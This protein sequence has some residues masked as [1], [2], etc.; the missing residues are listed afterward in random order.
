MIGVRLT[1]KLPEGVTPT[2]L[3][4]TIT[5]LLRKKGVVDKFVEFY[6]PG[7][8]TLT[9]ADRAMIANMAPENGATMLYFPVDEQTLDYLRL[10]GRPT[11]S[12]SK[13]TSR[14]SAS[15]ATAAAPTPNTPT[16]S[17][18]TWARSSPAWP[19]PSARRTASPL[20]QVQAEFPARR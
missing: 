8:D 20:G 9:L 14:R 11:E 6:G 1:G 5:Q 15:S 10:T 19:G 16:R 18:W 7:L 12:W 13:P 4:L 3:T 17:N 2:D